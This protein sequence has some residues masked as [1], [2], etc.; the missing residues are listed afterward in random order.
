MGETRSARPRPPADPSTEIAGPGSSRRPDFAPIV[1]V[2]GRFRDRSHGRGSRPGKSGRA[3]GQLGR[4]AMPGEPGV[5][6]GPERERDGST[7]DPHGGG[8]L[9][10]LGIR[11]G[12]HRVADAFAG[13]PSSAGR[14]RRPRSTA[15]NG[16][17]L[18]TGDAGVGKTWLEAG[19]TR[20]PCRLPMGRRRPH[21]VERPDRPLPADR[22]NGPGTGEMLG[23]GR[24]GSTTS[25]NALADAALECD[26][27]TAWSSRR[28][29]TWSMRCLGRGPR[30]GQPARAARTDS[31]SM[32]LVGQ[33]VPGSPGSRPASRS[34]RSR[35][36]WPARVHLGPIDVAEAGELL[37]LRDPG[38]D[39]AVTAEDLELA[40]PR[41][42]AATPR[43]CSGRSG[44]ISQARI[45]MRPEIGSIE[46]DRRVTRA[47]EVR[48]IEKC[49]RPIRPPGRLADAADRSRRQ[50]GRPLR[51]RG[52]HDRGRLVSDQSATRLASKTRRPRMTSR[53]PPRPRPPG[54]VARR[55]CRTTTPRSRPGENGRAIRQA[56]SSGRRSRQDGGSRSIDRRGREAVEAEP[57]T[58]PPRR[59]TRRTVRVEGR[60]QHK[61]APFGQLFSRMARPREP[62]SQ[63]PEAGESALA[64]QPRRP[65]P[66]SLARARG[67]PADRKEQV[68]PGRRRHGAPQ[69]SSFSRG[70]GPRRRRRHL[71]F[72][73]R[74]FGRRSMLERVADLLNRP[75]TAKGPLDPFHRVSDIRA[76][77]LSY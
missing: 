26:E 29:T 12:R 15:S 46:P 59:R 66:A 4:R 45:S 68:S 63:P 75:R 76:C 36:G 32:I 67:P 74:R 7:D 62:E 71:L 69:T 44:G 16:P 48:P 8:R 41:R 56:D 35:R 18:L 9:E 58:C 2:W 1:P 33:T 51:L 37:S 54:T 3:E 34:P 5:L 10:I 40:P 50:L 55:R 49:P 38:R 53:I 60:K 70:E 57:T 52:E 14:P 20:S 47:V 64:R 72:P 13:L 27:R 28:P 24:P 6:E 22:T 19:S 65:D 43:A 61:F 21:P 17:I 77:M 11:P 25:S 39:W 31:R 73:F 23:S 42:R 30:P